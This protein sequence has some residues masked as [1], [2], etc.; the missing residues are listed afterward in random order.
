MP[1]APEAFTLN[2]QDVFTGTSWA[3]PFPDW[4]VPPNT[5]WQLYAV[6]AYIK[7]TARVRVW[8]GVF[9]PYV[10]GAAPTFPGWWE[11]TAH[12]PVR[13]IFPPGQVLRLNRLAAAV[14]DEYDLTLWIIKHVGADTLPVWA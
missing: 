11:Y 10:P 1:Q 2:A 5:W 8:P 9:P 3:Q 14:G 13:A 6:S 12:S 4:K 7:G